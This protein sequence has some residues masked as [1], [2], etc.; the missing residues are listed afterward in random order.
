M[1]AKKVPPKTRDG[2][3][4]SAATHE[5]FQVGRGTRYGRPKC[6]ALTRRSA[7]E[8]SAA[9]KAKGR[10]PVR[11]SPPDSNPGPNLH[12]LVAYIAD[13]ELEVDRLR[14][15]DQFLRYTFDRELETFRSALEKTASS[16]GA[17]ATLREALNELTDVVEDL[18]VGPT[19]HSAQDHVT[20]I[21][22]RPL[23]ERAFR[24]QQRTSDA[25]HA[26]LH[27]E[28]STEAVNWFPVRF[29]HILDN[30]LSNALKYRDP[31]KGESRVSVV[32]KLH[33]ETIELRI[34]DN[35]LG[36]PTDS[37]MTA[38]E[39]LNQSSHERRPGTGV[40]LA[41][42]KLLIEQ[43]GGSLHVESNEGK[44]SQFVATLP[45]FDL[46]DYLA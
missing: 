7:V 12:Q 13:L 45:R 21:S 16:N 11:I 40:G 10:T 19:G 26:V 38:T 22:V 25:P 37:L 14:K 6:R 2:S 31:N 23:V 43:S 27:L 1:S 33:A 36:I 32:L 39:Y 28:L 41:V 15:Q 3:T 35:G 42:V 46:G 24:W 8:S 20:E 5:P 34:T 29:R 18:D 30:L 9:K 44:G 17:S 4:E